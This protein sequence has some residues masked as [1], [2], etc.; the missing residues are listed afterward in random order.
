MSAE[1]EKQFTIV[2]N[3]MQLFKP[4]AQTYL[5]DVPITESLTHYIR[6]LLQEKSI[7]HEL[8]EKE[9]T[10]YEKFVEQYV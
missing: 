7:K 4:E 8:L 10:L 3:G 2:Q 9:F 5:L 1:E 6:R